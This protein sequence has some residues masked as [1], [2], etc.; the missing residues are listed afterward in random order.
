[1]GEPIQG[2]WYYGWNIVV[3]SAILTLITVGMR[4]S[5]GPFFLPML[6]DFDMSRTNLSMIVAVGMFVYGVGMPL[7][8]YMERRFGTR[9]VLLTGAVIVFISSLGTMLSKTPISLLLSFGIFLSLGLALTSPVALTPL[10]ARWFVKRRGQA[11]FYLTTGSMAGIAIMT[12]VNTMLINAFGWQQTFL[13]FAIVFVLL[14]LPTALF[15][16][17]EDVPEGADE[18][19]STIGVRTIE[20]TPRI[21]QDPHPKLT[22]LQAIKTLPFW[23]ISL[24]LF[25]C[26]YSMNLLGSHGVPML[27]DH[28]FSEMTASFGVGLIGLVAIPSTIILGK[29][30][31]RVPRKNILSVIYLIRGLGFVFLVWATFAY[32]LYLIALIAGFVWAGS[33]ALSS[34]ILAD[35][36][37]VRLLGVLYGWA[38]F[39][40]QIAGTISSLLGGWGYDKFNTHWVSFGS[41][42]VV[43]FIASF[44]SFQLPKRLYE[45]KK[46][47]KRKEILV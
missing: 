3:A 15:I 39:S 35:I 46:E 26:G 13:I 4:M 1:M 14:V 10:I 44:I 23:Q 16:I 21:V 30:S 9:T 36:Y 25:A 31:D 2:K 40:H 12:P 32:Q 29:L 34:A 20:T 38:Y 47:S 11:L 5:I 28:G 24:G 6:A 27:I 45:K 43:L 42:A 17:R 18:G 7:A 8:G 37:G 22:V 41:A 33:V 19:P